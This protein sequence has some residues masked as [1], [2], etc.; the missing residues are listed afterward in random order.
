MLSEA[1]KGL[2]KPKRFSI[3]FKAEDWQNLD[4][5]FK[6]FK[7]PESPDRTERFRE[8]LRVLALQSDGSLTTSQASSVVPESRSTPQRAVTEKGEEPPQNRMAKELYLK[9][10]AGDEPFKGLKCPYDARKV[11]NYLQC[12]FCAKDM[13]GSFTERK[14]RYHQISRL[15]QCQNCIEVAEAQK[16]VKALDRTERQASH[17]VRRKAKVDYPDDWVFSSS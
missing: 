14:A 1:S 9:A 12:F 5:A 13:K 8:L 11:D 6:K 10:L 3:R 15:E 4:K 17:Y 2:E 7:I 16:R